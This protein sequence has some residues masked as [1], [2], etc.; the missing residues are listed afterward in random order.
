MFVQRYSAYASEVRSRGFCASAR[1]CASLLDVHST[2]EL[3]AGGLSE[4][5]LG[6]LALLAECAPKQS[7]RDAAFAALAVHP[8]W[9]APRTRPRLVPQA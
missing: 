8:Q 6:D 1:T 9:L 3:V 7:Q 2:A 4:L 5:G